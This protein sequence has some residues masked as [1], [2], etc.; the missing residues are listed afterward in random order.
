M[1]VPP[2]AVSQEQRA[3]QVVQALLAL[4]LAQIVFGIWPVIGKLV[5]PYLP[6]RALVGT[7]IGLSG[8]LLFLLTRPW[9]S[10]MTRREVLACAGL[11]LLGVVAN[12]ALFIEGLAR[13]TP[14]NAAVLG[15]LIPCYTLLIAVLLR[16]EALDPRRMLGVG[17]ALL[18]ALWLVGAERLDFGVDRLWGN[19]ALCTNTLLY[20]LYLVLSRPLVARH[21]ALAVTGWTFGWSAL[22]V[23]PYSIGALAVIDWPGLPAGVWAGVA[24]IV[25]GAS[26]VAYLLNAFAL[27]H[28]S[29]STVAVFVYLQP[30]VTGLAA[31]TALGLRPGW[32]VLTAAGLIFAGVAVTAWRR[33]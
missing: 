20:S 27:R 6:A 13:S 29:A 33:R 4:A 25:L 22:E 1:P 18:G 12:Q 26:V 2:L 31:G 30:I 23:L 19:L 17:L 14:I 15:C 3:R 9:R 28:V 7:R 5:L 11:A 8:P 16:Q 21:G 10:A 24:Y 32:Q